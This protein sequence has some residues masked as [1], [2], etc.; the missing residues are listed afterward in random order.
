MKKRDLFRHLIVI[1]TVKANGILSGMGFLVKTNDEKV[2]IV[3]AAHVAR[4]TIIN[5]ELWFM[6]LNMQTPL[7][8]NINQINKY[9]EW[10]Y[11]PTADIAIIEVKKI[12]LDAIKRETNET[13]TNTKI[14]ILDYCLD[15]N[16][17]ESNLYSVPEREESISIFGSEEIIYY[18]RKFSPLSIEAKV[19]SD[20]TIQHN[21]FTNQIYNCF[22]IDKPSKQGF[23]GSPA[24][25][26]GESERCYGIATGTISDNT[27]GKMGIILHS[28]YIFDIINL[29]YSK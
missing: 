7:L 6:D 22:Y 18:D 26:I 25:V 1:K 24:F 23:S 20:L 5:T 27:G 2:F 17:I 15:I 13:S 28:F 8:V 21:D 16:N 29:Y 3:S 14:N 10:F 11:H 19:G 4:D 12:H 9:N